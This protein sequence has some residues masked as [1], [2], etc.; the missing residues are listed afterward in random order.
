MFRLVALAT[1]LIGCRVSLQ[2]APS[3]G[4]DDDDG[5][6]MPAGRVCKV[7]TTSA[8]CLEAA[9]GNHSD[10]AFIEASIFKG[11]CAFSGCHNG[12][13][14]PQGKIDLTAGQSHA[15]LV[16]YASAIDETRKLVVPNDLSSSY[17]M[18]MLHDI[19][20]SEATPAADAPPDDVGYMPMGNKPLCCQKL[21]AIERWIMAG[22]PS[23]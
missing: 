3:A 17:L 7:D 22:A 18:L 11:Q 12:A 4:D 14:T 20:P 2:D 19:E 21:D 15:H 13:N 1:L 23:N 10:L 9:S 6:D 5:D 16:N 8:T